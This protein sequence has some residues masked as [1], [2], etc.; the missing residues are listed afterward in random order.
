MKLKISYSAP[1]PAFLLMHFVSD[2]VFAMSG[3]L[4]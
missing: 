2:A 1:F 3:H 4:K